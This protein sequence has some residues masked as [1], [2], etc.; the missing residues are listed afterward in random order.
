MIS[1]NADVGVNVY[2]NGYR[3]FDEP[4]RYEKSDYYSI[5]VPPEKLP[6]VGNDLCTVLISVDGFFVPSEFG[7]YQDDRELG[8]R[9]N[10][11][12]RAA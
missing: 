9:M 10:Y 11:I 6:A 7:F 5:L 3:M 12:G 4:F 1:A 2:V 8:L